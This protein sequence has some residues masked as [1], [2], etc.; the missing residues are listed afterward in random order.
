MDESSYGLQY[1][2]DQDIPDPSENAGFIPDKYLEN[3]SKL[4]HEKPLSNVMLRI[5]IPFLFLS[6]YKAVMN[7][8]DIQVISVTSLSNLERFRDMTALFVASNF[9][10]M[11]LWPLLWGVCI[12]FYTYS[13]TLLNYSSIKREDIIF[14]VI[15]IIVCIFCIYMAETYLF[16][17]YVLELFGASIASNTLFSSTDYIQ[18]SACGSFTQGMCFLFLFHLMNS[19]KGF[20]VCMLTLF[21]LCIKQAL[22]F[23][24]A[25]FLNMNV[26]GCALSSNI[27]YAI[28]SIY[29]AYYL[30]HKEIFKLDFFRLRPSW[31]II[32]SILWYSL[33]IFIDS[34]FQVLNSFVIYTILMNVNRN[35]TTDSEVELISAFGVLT[36]TY[37][38]VV[39]IP[40]SICQSVIPILFSCSN[41]L[42][43]YGRYLNC[44]QNTYYIST[45]VS[46]AISSPILYLSYTL[47]NDMKPTS[48]FMSIISYGSSFYVC[49]LPFIP[50]IST[51]VSMLISSYNIDLLLIFQTIV[52][53][54]FYIILPYSFFFMFTEYSVVFYATPA[55]E[56]GIS[57]LSQIMY[58]DLLSTNNQTVDEDMSNLEYLKIKLFSRL[59]LYLHIQTYKKEQ[60]EILQ[61][62]EYYE[63]QQR[64]DELDYSE[65]IEI[66][67]Q[68]LFRYKTI[69]ENYENTKIKSIFSNNF[70]IFFKKVINP[71]T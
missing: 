23:I 1:S 64:K 62:I 71:L 32:K 44:I 65:E 70:K 67:N 38:I 55:C 4:L 60:K 8:S 39:T 5:G 7:G 20:I 54:L 34:V 68:Q 12:G 30:T 40:K 63:E 25:Y 53:F 28:I 47:F 56:A 52:Y 50:C 59:D 33:P 6:L 57:I 14:N 21:S 41:K 29:G 16:G 35:L 17:K 15:F 61:Q 10:Y 18:I 45:I 48:L 31:S 69:E 3:R 46:L 2:P 37:R 27:S 9:E 19:N 58:W 13:I 36:I 51:L 26:L 66:L 42:D 11:F 49:S 24:F 22:N 43:Y